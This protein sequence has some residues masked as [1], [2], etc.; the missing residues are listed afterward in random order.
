MPVLFENDLYRVSQPLFGGWRVLDKRSGAT[1][2]PNL[3]LVE[4]MGFV[5]VR[6]GKNQTYRDPMLRRTAENALMFW[7]AQASVFPREQA[8]FEFVQAP[9]EE[10]IDT[11][12]SMAIGRYWPPFLP[13]R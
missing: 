10:V 3:N 6:V 9:E 1:I 11:C 2:K 12:F 13:D 4:R 8:A 5:W 7:F